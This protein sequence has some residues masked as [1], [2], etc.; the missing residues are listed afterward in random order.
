M[1]VILTSLAAMLWL[2]AAPLPVWAQEPAGPA[3]DQ[4]PH[5]EI[6]TADVRLDGRTLFRVRGVS[7][8]A[9]STRA[10]A[11]EERIEAVAADPSIAIDALH[12]IEGDGLLRIVAGNRPIMAIAPADARLEQV[13]PATL[14]A[15]HLARIRQSI[16]EYRADRSSAV[17]RAAVL[18]TA[19]AALLSLLLA[20]IVVWGGHRIG[21]F[22]EGHLRQKVHAVGIQTF[23]IVRAERIRGAVRGLLRATAGLALLAIAFGFLSYALTQFPWTRGSSAG[24]VSL[25]LGPLQTMAEGFVR[26]I[27]NLIFLGVLFVVVRFLLRITRLFF[28]SVARGLV[29]L[30]NFDPEWSTPTYKIVRFAI[31]AFA[32]VVAYPYVPGSDSAAFK[33]VSLFV[34]VLLS[35]G[36]S[37]A[38]ANLIAGYSMTYRRAFRVGDRVKIAGLI[39]D[40]TE[41]KLQVT[42][43][44]SPKN[45]EIV[46]PN[47]QILNGEVVNYST[48]ALTHGLILHTEVGIGYETPWRQVE[49]MLMMAAESTPGVLHE[50]R[51]FVLQK[52]LGDFAITYELNAYCDKP[53]AMASLYTALHR[54]VLDVF[55]Q[56]GVQIMTPAYEGD[57]ASPKLVPP[58][59]WHVA[60]ARVADA[61]STT[62]SAQAEAFVD[63]RREIGNVELTSLLP[64][65]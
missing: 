58:G 51:P 1:S 5:L 38:I 21:R 11:I 49:A 31:V 9:A 29:T 2:L 36:S 52:A 41:Q 15:M 44:R 47:S 17:L 57:P 42:R 35:I 33:G 56:Y 3:A 50:P 16:A 63:G 7:S 32:I 22:A 55:N 25:I 48:L 34:G 39:G 59:L 8:L 6:D 13:Q 65:V 60:P 26:Q 14:T 37:S 54:Q 28:D 23:E 20:G 30:S 19:G 12:V 61:S 64:R 62:A 10:R 46:I 43:L 40:V 45:E 27:P 18:R 53:Q 24:L 4:A